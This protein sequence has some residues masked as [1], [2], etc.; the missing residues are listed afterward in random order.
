MR[1]A[2]SEEKKNHLNWDL[3][4]LDVKLFGIENLDILNGNFVM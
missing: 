4:G 3:D 1:S 2:K